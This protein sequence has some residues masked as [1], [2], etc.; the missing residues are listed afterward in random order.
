L[1]TDARLKPI[2]YWKVRWAEDGLSPIILSA[3]T[4][5]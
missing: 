2:R 3:A 1:G 5:S 4:S